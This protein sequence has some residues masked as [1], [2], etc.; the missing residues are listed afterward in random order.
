MRTI[1]TAAMNNPSVV[2]VF[3]AAL[4][5]FGVASFITMPRLEDPEINPPF[6]T[7]VTALPGASAEMV[8]R[9][10]TE[11]L[12]EAISELEDIKDLV[13]VSKT[14]YSKIDIELHAGVDVLEHWRTMRRLIRDAQDQLPDD[15]IQSKIFAE[16]I[17]DV[18]VMTLAVV[19]PTGSDPD[20]VI[21][22]LD[23]L[24]HATEQAIG[25][26][27]GVGRVE[28]QGNL[29][30]EVAVE[31]DLKKLALRR[32]PF[33][34]VLGALR[35][36]N[37]R[38]PGGDV[39]VAGTNYAVRT[40][41]TFESVDQVAQVTV[42]V[43]G[44]GTPVRVSDVATVKRAPAQA[45]DRA[46]YLQRPA[47]L[48][49][50]Y[51][52]SDWSITR[53]GA[54]LREAVPSLA[55]PLPEGFE[56]K[57]VSDQSQRVN[58]RIGHF[59]LNLFEG[60]VLVIGVTALALGLGGMVP[61]AISLPLAMLMGLGGMNALG[62]ALHQVSISSLVIVIGM[63]VDN[64][65]V[66]TENVERHMRLGASPKQA[67]IDGAL[68]VWGSVLTSTLTTVVA[69]TPLAF[70]SD[71]TGDFIRTL[72]IVVCLTLGSSYL[73]AMLLTPIVAAR[74]Y[75]PRETIITRL[76]RR[77]LPHFDRLLDRALARPLITLALSGLLLAGALSSMNL[78]GVRFF[79]KAELSQFHV[80][81]TAPAEANIAV[82][83]ETVRMVEQVLD[84]IPDVSHYASALGRGMPRFYY[85]VFPVRSDEAHGQILVTLKDD[86]QL[87]AAEVV[88]M[89]NRRF[90]NAPGVRIEPL[91]IEQGPPVGAPV[92]VRLQSKELAPIRRAAQEV[93]ARIEG[94]PEV[95]R[96]YDDFGLDV[97][98]IA[99][100][101]DR[102]Q[103]SRAGLNEADIATA[104]RLA[105]A[106]IEA[107]T[108]R[109]A[110]EE[111]SVVVRG[112]FEQE[113]DFS[114][115][116]NLFVDSSVTQE[117]VPIRQV[118]TVVPDFTLGA[119]PHR[120]QER[121]I[122][123]RVWNRSKISADELE[124]AVQRALEGFGVPQGV[125]LSF[126]GETEHRSRS[127]ES[128]GRL[129]IIAIFAV[130]VILVFQFRSLIKPFAILVALPLSAIG[131]IL[132]LWVLGA[133]LGFMAILGLVALIGVVVNDSIVLVEFVE[134]CRR[135]EMPVDKA[136]RQGA[137]IRLR[138]IAMTTV[139]TVFGILPLALFGGSLWRPMGAVI[140]FGLITSSLLTL[141][142]VPVLYRQLDRLA[143]LFKRS[144]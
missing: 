107:T 9:L 121:T 48:I 89:L 26:M 135:Q 90:S 131:G 1:L 87:T 20:G 98:R 112:R 82:T 10:V 116:E 11:P 33:T 83:E 13:S 39:A 140:I 59:M 29:K 17:L 71:N 58:K 124:V 16:N 120:D 86:A 36:A 132:G 99:V 55:A 139:T 115:L 31:V 136:V 24:A 72:P 34:R 65:I 119:I 80:L 100:E 60:L 74:L 104:V 19:A 46:R 103:A 30:E 111:L 47:V 2:F 40:A 75:R 57:I 125:E 141:I 126:G 4:A 76:E 68:E 96:V 95:E 114:G 50:P 102:A 123:V 63:L 37:P 70:M 127:F 64:S 110:D 81:V 28:L 130:L 8:E 54:D 22:V 93:I 73:A 118:A 92:V 108:L 53:L 12:E 137:R 18:G 88:E 129:A 44:T 49:T 5:I 25:K 52:Q 6:A 38:L 143:S 84:E 51:M 3:F 117:A 85:N 56:L 91:E 32:V 27:P 144:S 128:L 15:A 43:A 79:P 109:D 41:R 78:L 105:V 35:A 97:P 61:V 133:P 66:I 14:G 67:A 134:I 62:L 142:I 94:L 45:R 21:T 69:F 113:K 7:V 122:T 23:G 42:D 138:P 77:V 101:V 106:G